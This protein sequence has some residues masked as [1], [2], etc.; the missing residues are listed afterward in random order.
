VDIAVGDVLDPASLPAVMAGVHTAYYLVHSMGGSGKFSS[1]DIQAADNF[2]Q[3]AA[4]A[5]VQQ[6][7]YLGG[8]GD[9]ETS[10]SE[11]LASRQETGA[12]LRRHGV[13]VTEF[14]A[15][16]VVGSGSLS[17]E[18]LRHLVE[19]IPIM[20][21]P[22]WVFTRSQPIAVRDVLSYLVAGLE[23]PPGEDE[24]LEIGGADIFTYAEMMMTYARIRGLRR[25]IIRVPVLSPRLSS[26]W[27]HWMTPI[28]AGIARPLIMGLKNEMVVRDTQAQ[29]RF[30]DIKPLDYATAVELAL[31]RINEGDIKTLWSDAQ[32]S[33]QLD[34][35]P[36]TLT[37][38]QG[39]LIERRQ[40]TVSAPPDVVFRE[41]SSLGGEKGWPPFTWL[42][43]LRGTLDRLI[44]GVGM[45]RGRRHPQELRVG[46]ALDFW[47]VEKVV[48]DHLVR[49]RTEMK[50][51][52]QGWLQFEAQPREDGRTDLIQTA[53][54]DSRGLS[55]LLYW[56]GIY[57]LHGLVFSRMIKAIAQK[58][59]AT[60]AITGIEQTTAGRSKEITL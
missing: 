48:P 45:R 39:M 13:P 49:L 29:E 6:I 32:A 8:L 47:R 34:Q 17:F 57:P 43:H 11:H 26:Y 1:R 35:K 20:V 60:A 14:R 56:Y 22:K 58:A 10:L 28:P 55:G 12:T 9:P 46:E 24:I 54:F 41:F 42:W 31:R 37:Q 4:K 50:L 7:I 5:G 18:M 30:P 27:V 19:R 25:W 21:A 53:Y 52:G 44:G 51:P 59:E 15:G 40:L 3:A 23:N 16:M 38:E 33:S 2:S 36:V